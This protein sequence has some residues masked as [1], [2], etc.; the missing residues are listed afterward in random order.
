MRMTKL[1]KDNLLV[2]ERV[3]IESSHLISP[4]TEQGL[5]SVYFIKAYSGDR[6]AYIMGGDG[7]PLEY[8]DIKSALRA[9]R[10]V[11]KTV[12]VTEI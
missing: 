7:F 1:S 4:M 3:K 11:N 6:C 5:T 12:S 8:A 10:R 2:A 9:I